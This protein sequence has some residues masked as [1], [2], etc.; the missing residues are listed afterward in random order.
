MLKN[1]TL[2][3]GPLALALALTSATSIGAGSAA[4]GDT[5]T[6]SFTR[7]VAL[8]GVTLVPGTYVFEIFDSPGSID[9]VRVSRKANGHHE[10]LGMTQRVERPTRLKGT[11]AVT[12][13]ES[14]P[15]EPAPISVWYPADGSDG[16]KFRY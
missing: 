1:R 9:I 14:R 7:A 5:A 11:S 6:L 4:R 10:F 16:R 2:V 15:G 12:F 8:P 13:G 3:V